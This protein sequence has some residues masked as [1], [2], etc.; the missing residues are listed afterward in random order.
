[1][2]G[3][4][5]NHQTEHSCTVFFCGLTAHIHL[6]SLEY[7]VTLGASNFVVSFQQGRTLQSLQ[8]VWE[9]TERDKYPWPT[10]H[11]AVVRT[12]TVHPLKLTFGPSCQSMLLFW[13]NADT[14]THWTHLCS[15]LE[16]HV[17][18]R[19]TH[20]SLQ[21]LLCVWRQTVINWEHPSGTSTE[22]LHQSKPICCKHWNVCREFAYW[23]CEHTCV[24]YICVLYP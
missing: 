2:C 15:P 16:Y 21:C 6:Y 1:M 17:T 10:A 4:L 22:W 14:H 8:V 13:W 23:H 12:Q 9:Y 5:S 3:S 19:C 18:I 11:R 20:Q 24:G 7:F